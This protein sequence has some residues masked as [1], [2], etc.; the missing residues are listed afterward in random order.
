[1]VVG[2]QRF[3]DHFHAHSGA[4]VLIGGAACDAWMTAN[5]LTF[6]RTKD[7]DI[8][9]VADAVDAAFADRF[10]AFVEEGGYEV[11][12]RQ[13]TGKREFFRFYKPKGDDY[14]FMLELFSRAPAGLDVWP[15]QQVVPV[16]AEEPVASL[17]TILMDE[18]YYRL[19]LQ[20]RYVDD[21]IPMVT[22]AGLIPLKAKAWLDLQARRDAG[23]HVDDDDIKKRRN[24]IF[25]L[26]LT[27][28]EEPVEIAQAIRTDL[29]TFLAAFPDGAAEWPSIAS[30]LHV[31]MGARPKLSL[32]DLRQAIAAYFRLD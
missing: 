28:T 14:P 26:A 2:L 31:T 23:Q 4:F 29:T 27:L 10:K 30:A 19:V 25:R 32:P 21:G 20:T 18:G 16:P 13:G 11:R 24:D 12:Q 17:S 5:A 6:R 8:V 1:M 7:L 22:V 9:L 15:G 3:R